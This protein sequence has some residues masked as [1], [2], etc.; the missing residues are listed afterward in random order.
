MKVMIRLTAGFCTPERIP[1]FPKQTPNPDRTTRENKHLSNPLPKQKESKNRNG[2]PSVTPHDL[3]PTAYH[4]PYIQPPPLH[5]HETQRNTSQ[6]R[7]G[8]LNPSP[9]PQN[10]TQWILSPQRRSAARVST[11][12][13]R[14]RLCRARS[15][16]SSCR[17]PERLGGSVKAKARRR[18]REPGR[19]K[20]MRYGFNHCIETSRDSQLPHGPHS[21]IN[22]GCQMGE[23][24]EDVV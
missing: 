10:T 5:P 19:P 1:W 6:Y 16:R 18:Q 22:F 2:Y 20:G 24:T 11:R 9:L 23:T 14:A 12:S 15:T 7:E 13:T 8:G 4:K 17:T 21:E 3:N